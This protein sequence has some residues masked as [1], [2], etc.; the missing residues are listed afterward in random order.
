MAKKILSS[1]FELNGIAPN[2]LLQQVESA[3]PY[4]FKNEL[5]TSTPECAYL[6]KLKFYKKNL[7]A[8]K[9]INLTEYFHICLSAHW[10]TAGS[11]VPTNVDNQ[12]REGLWK[13]K[14]IKKHIEQ[15]ARLTIES[16]KWDYTQVTNRKSYNPLNKEVISTHE[17]TWLSV[18]IGAYCALKKNKRLD[19]A[20]EVASVIW[21]EIE[22][23]KSLL[24]QLRENQEHIALIK[25]APLV[26]HNLGDLDRVMVQW[27]M[28]ES[29]PFCQ[30][31]FKLGHQKNDGN[32]IFIFSGNVNKEFTSK[33][34]HRHMSM[35]QPKCIRKSNKFLIPVGPFMDDWGKA[36]GETER[37]DS[38]EK[39]EV[40]TA[41][42]EGYK[43][44]D[45]AFGYC[46]AFGSM[47]KELPDGLK[48]LDGELP[49]DIVAEITKSKFAELASINQEDFEQTY[50]TRLKEFK[51]PA[52]GISF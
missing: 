42:Y 9:S 48:S 37:L 52:T 8:L 38:L 4:L 15:M 32:E 45:E 28:N 13:H 49:F 11:F 47:M 36:L 44:Q 18:A 30:K 7:K 6:E 16:W 35:R 1:G 14:T 50:I 51:C 40:I 10:T 3:T 29:D 33:E 24:T 22:K 31:V 19:L 21:A 5:K 17:G 20:E 12:I 2:L 25:A 27:N 41:L 26:A 34:N 39:A 23:E 46:R 43:R